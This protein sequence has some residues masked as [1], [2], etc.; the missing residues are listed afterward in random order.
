MYINTPY[1]LPHP[2][3]TSA[4]FI[5]DV[6]WQDFVCWDPQGRGISG[7][8]IYLDCISCILLFFL[9]LGKHSFR[10][11]KKRYQEK[12]SAVV[13]KLKA[14]FLYSLGPDSSTIDHDYQQYFSTQNAR[15][16][17]FIFYV[18][19]FLFIRIE[20]CFIFEYW[21]SIHYLLFYWLKITTLSFWLY[22]FE[23]S[24]FDGKI[25]KR[26]VR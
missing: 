15:Y 22:R 1:P 10:I 11:Y 25:S 8:I 13:D 16:H 2:L 12:K 4:S 23:M 20:N 3:N 14:V 21:D 9:H 7:N 5:C 18:D 6:F 17:C 24:Q 19:L 26:T